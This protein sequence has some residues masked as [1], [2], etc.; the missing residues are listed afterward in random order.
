MVFQSKSYFR[1]ECNIERHTGNAIA[2]SDFSKCGSKILNYTLS[3]KAE[4]NVNTSH[5]CIIR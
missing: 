1:K 5:Y 3:K 2:L 4:Q